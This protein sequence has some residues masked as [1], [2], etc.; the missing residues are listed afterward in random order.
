MAD[1]FGQINL[2]LIISGSSESIHK[3][4]MYEIRGCLSVSNQ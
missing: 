2:L 4:Q 1:D 3:N